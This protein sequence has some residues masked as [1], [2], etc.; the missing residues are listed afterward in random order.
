MAV[1]RSTAS[2]GVHTP[3]ASTRRRAREPAAPR[4]A[5]T[6]P[7]SPGTPTLSLKVSNPRSAQRFASAATAASG[8]A[9]SV[10]L[11]RTGWADSAPSIRQS[12]MPASLAARSSCAISRA[13]LAAGDIPAT[14]ST[15]PAS[16]SRST[17]TNCGW[18]SS[19]ICRASAGVSGPPRSDIAT[20]SP[21]PSIPASVRIRTRTISRRSRRPRAVT[22]GSRKVSAYGTVSTAV[23]FSRSGREEQPG[24][25]KDAERREQGAGSR[26]GCIQGRTVGAGHHRRHWSMNERGGEKNEEPPR[27]PAGRQERHRHRDERRPDE[28]GVEVPRAL[29]AQPHGQRH[30]PGTAVGV[31]VAGVVDDED[32]GGEAADRQGEPERQ[33]VQVLELDVVGAVHG[34]QSE[35]EEDEELTQPR[36]A[37]RS[38]STR[39][40]HA[41]E[42]RGRTDD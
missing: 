6:C 14:G 24:G 25:Q 39:V 8:P 11:H 42:D 36:V 29:P 27:G 32:R 9:T 34:H 26:Q 18:A 4:T 5:S 28:A 10:A 30:L 1:R 35:E 17:P 23:T 21:R 7:T 19:E 16:E 3:F 15:R 33:P 38:R 37:I 22:Y 13:A 2:W 12:G 20:A 40:Q 31:D 41:G